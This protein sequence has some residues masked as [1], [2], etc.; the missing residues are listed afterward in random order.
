MS[1]HASSRRPAGD[2]PDLRAV[3]FAV[4]RG[5]WAIVLCAL[6]FAAVAAIAGSRAEVRY[7]ASTSMLV[8]R[9]V[10]D[11][12]SLR[13]AGDRAPT[14]GNLASSRRKLPPP[15]QWPAR[16]RM[17]AAPRTGMPKQR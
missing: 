14:Y 2:Y 10:A 8:G 3:V 13:A 16:P 6:G 5:W 9:P 17:Y 15:H 1:A 12:A 11:L 7:E 4:R